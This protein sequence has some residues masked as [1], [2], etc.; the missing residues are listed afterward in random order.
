M[1][2]CADNIRLLVAKVS[3]H[4][5]RLEKEVAPLSALEHIM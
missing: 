1:P 4:I 5:K 2:I 3:E